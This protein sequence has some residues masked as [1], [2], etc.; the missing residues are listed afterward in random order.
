MAQIRYSDFG[1]RLVI[2]SDD[3]EVEIEVTGPDKMQQIAESFLKERCASRMAR[4]RARRHLEA[5]KTAKAYL[6]IAPFHNVLE[7]KR[8]FEEIDRLEHQENQASA[9]DGGGVNVTK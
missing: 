3:G 4:T 5:L 6:T 1:H 8:F 2:T 7:V 9:E